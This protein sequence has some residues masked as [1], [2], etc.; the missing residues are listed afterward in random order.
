MNAYVK[1]FWSV[2][3][4]FLHDFNKLK[5]RGFSLS[6]LWHL[7]SL[8]R[9]N[10]KLWS[11]LYDVK[12]KEQ[13][14]HHVEDRK[15]V[16]DVFNTYIL[17]HKKQPLTKNKNGKVLVNYDTILRFPSR[18]F[19]DYFDC[20]KTMILMADTDEKNKPLYNIP[21]IYLSNYKANT[22]KAVIQLQSQAKAL[23]KMYERH[24][25]YNDMIF[26]KVLLKKIVETVNYIEQ[27]VRLLADVSFSC[28]VVSS[29]HSYIS[30][31]LTLVAMEQGIPTICMQHGIIANEFGYIPKIATIDAVYGYFEDNWY[32]RIGIPKESIA[33]VGHPRF[34]QA[35]TNPSIARSKFYNQLGLD[36]SKKTLL[37]VVRGNRNIA[38]WRILIRTICKRLPL[39]ILV[40][41]FPGSPPHPLVKEFPFV[42]S[43]QTYNLYDILLNV[44]SVVSYPSTVGLEAMLVNKPIFILNKKLPNSTGYYD[45]LDEL[46]QTDPV[47]LGDLI[48]RLFTDP[49]YGNYVK[50]RREEFLRIAYPDQSIS[51][52]R[53]KRLINRLT[54]YLS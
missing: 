14:N 2:Y 30:R 21:I 33:I 47:K 26:Q 5:Y 1:N 37:I 38:K 9:H 3:L 15:E 54:G 34:D 17:S 12:F 28:I 22:L 43:T 8:T 23:F 52:E 24:H 49:S 6:Y 36:N 4:D 13:V 32:Q 16:Q 20:S 48:V 40:K 27:S 42:H 10:K 18:T 31:I 25:I 41:D 7:P 11:D 51:G 35:L 19:D 44:D 50:E 46:I 53:L 45:R 29:T 39:N